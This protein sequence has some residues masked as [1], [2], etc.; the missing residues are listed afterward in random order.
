MSSLVELCIRC[1]PRADSDPFAQLTVNRKQPCYEAHLLVLRSPWRIRRSQDRS[2]LHSLNPRPL[3]GKINMSREITSWQILSQ[4]TEFIPPQ[5][6]VKLANARARH[7]K[8]VTCLASQKILDHDELIR[9]DQDKGG[10]LRAVPAEAGRSGGLSSEISFFVRRR[11]Y[12]VG[13]QCRLCFELM[14]IGNVTSKK[15]SQTI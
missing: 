1:A 5:A 3:A 6:T 2:C 4:W 8:L 14:L 11:S 13:T 15:I 7:W 10:H 9:A 12:L